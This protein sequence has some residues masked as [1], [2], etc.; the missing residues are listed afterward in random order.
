MLAVLAILFDAKPYERAAAAAAVE[1][2]AIIAVPFDAKPYER[3]AT[4]CH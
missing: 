1:R 3:A 4:S 2:T